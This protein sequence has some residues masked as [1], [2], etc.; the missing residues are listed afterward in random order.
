MRF[1]TDAILGDHLRNLG[2]PES[3]DRVEVVAVRLR[4]RG[5][6]GDT[7]AARDATDDELAL[8]HSH[9]YLEL[10]KRE[11][12]RVQTPRYLSTGD[13]VIDAH[14]AAVTR[15]AAGGAIV[16]L[17]RSAALGEPVFALVRPP[18][19]HAERSRG[20]GFCVYNNAAVA[21][22]VYQQQTGGR[23][24]LVDFDYHH[25]NG[26]EDVAGR[27]LSY[28]SS[29]AS[30]AYPGTG[31]AMLREASDVVVDVPLPVTG[32]ET[33]AFVALWEALLREV[34]TKLEPDAIVAS[35]GFDYVAGDPVGDLGVDIS[36]IVPIA[37]AIERVAREHC[38]GRLAYILEGGYNIDAL[39]E[40]IA[41]LAQESSHAATASD[42]AD[43]AIMSA[44]QC[45]L[46]KRAAALVE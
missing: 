7:L 33:E 4:Q 18:G 38:G 32:I 35:A 40:S 45:E 11:L 12:E 26:S 5:L 27:G 19:H 1:V 23:V 10:A 31:Y 9:Q 24:V 44:G 30:P 3:P 34:V 15:R 2:H 28:I 13:V 42:T 41:L 6:L 8:V 37:G 29:H 22:R 25:G 14:T 20:M 36:A 43:A 16:A 39:T 21:A 46:L 17:E